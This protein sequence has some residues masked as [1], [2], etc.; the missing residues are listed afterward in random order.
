MDCPIYMKDLWQEDCNSFFDSIVS[1]RMTKQIEVWPSTNNNETSCLP[2]ELTNELFN[3]NPEKQRKEV[4]RDCK[5]SYECHPSHPG[6]ANVLKI[7]RNGTFGRH[8]VAK[9]NIKVGKTV[10]V[11][12]HFLKSISP[13]YEPF[14]CQ[15]C[16]EKNNVNFISCDSCS[17]ARFCDVECRNTKNLHEIDCNIPY[18]QL[19]PSSFK[20]LIRSIILAVSFFPNAAELISF[21]ESVIADEKT[22]FPRSTLD[23]PSKY[24]AFLLLHPSS[25]GITLEQV[26]IS[27]LQLERM[28]LIAN[29][30]K[31]IAEK[32]FLLN[33]IA[34]HQ[35]V[36]QGNSFADDEQTS[37]GI[38]SSLFNHSCAPNL[39]NYSRGKF[40]CITTIRPVK[41]GEQLLISY[42]CDTTSSTKVRQLFLRNYFRFGCR[43][44]KCIAP[45]ISRV[46]Q[47]RMIQDPNYKFIC[48]FDFIG[49]LISCQNVFFQSY[50]HNA[51]ASV[52]R[53]CVEFLN[54]HG[55][56]PWTEKLG[57]VTDVYESVRFEKIDQRYGYDPVR[58]C[59]LLI[60]LAI[61]SSVVIIV[62]YGIF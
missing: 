51:K 16:F 45:F 25:V 10:V 19:Q 60:L 17:S 38:I 22:K 7:K 57:F 50:A 30:F 43:C 5:L 29:R 54:R 14:T 44:D 46:D 49:M 21:V 26:I 20:Q 55:H 41:K 8:I 24:H 9:R 28:E 23:F 36:L 11:E 53:A 61:F 37:I 27:S 47:Q 34:H 3:V 59:G 39:A 35:L 42:S 33:L 4:H 15:T 58:L 13:S 52:E 32:R 31:S 1:S 18:N 12:E 48:R 2:S 6:M 56:L 62:F 40:R